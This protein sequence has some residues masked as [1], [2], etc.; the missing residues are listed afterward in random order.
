MFS[1]NFGRFAGM[2]TK[3]AITGSSMLAML[4]AF[5][6]VNAQTTY[7]FNDENFLTP[8]NPPVT[9]CTGDACGGEIFLRM[10]TPVI[11]GGKASIG[12]W[13]RVESAL[14][15]TV[16]YLGNYLFHVA[17]G[18]PGIT[19]DSQECS[20]GVAE[21][22]PFAYDP[23]G[24][25]VGSN[26]PRSIT[27]TQAAPAST[28]DPSDRTHYTLSVGDFVQFGTFSCPVANG[29]GVNAYIL[30]PS[31]VFGFTIQAGAGDQRQLLLRAD[32]SFRYF[33]LNGDDPFEFAGTV[34]DD[35]TVVT[36]DIT[37]NLPGVTP[38][39]TASYSAVNVGE[40]T[41][42]CGAPTSDSPVVDGN[43]VTVTFSESQADNDCT[44]TFTVTLPDGSSYS[45]DQVVGTSGTPAEQLARAKA[46]Y[47][48]GS[49]DAYTAYL[50]A[51]NNGAVPVSSDGINEMPGLVAGVFVKKILGD[52]VKDAAT[53]DDVPSAFL[54]EEVQSLLDRTV[55][56][57]SGADF[58]S[59]ALTN[60]YS[61]SGTVRDVMSTQVS[62]V[63]NLSN[64]NVTV[65]GVLTTETRLVKQ[66]RNGNWRSVV[67]NDM[68][69]SVWY[70]VRN[71]GASNTC[72]GG[73]LPT[74]NGLIPAGPSTPVSCIM[75]TIVD[76]GM[77]DA[78][79][80][81]EPGSKGFISDPIV[82]VAESNKPP[83]P[84]GGGGGGGGGNGF[85]GIGSA[86]AWTIMA[87]LTVLGLSMLRRRRVTVR[88]EL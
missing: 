30:A 86:G 39:V 3:K 32:N 62:F 27:I 15:D 55:S 74:D 14:G 69:G 60:V 43:Q 24:L 6:N 83:L 38:T 85:L 75:I 37:N 53:R 59:S 2:V 54:A 47:I 46:S 9:E 5:A 65:G 10:G 11:E 26:D 17:T 88:S 80:R 40:P 87:L 50:K 73:W 57:P 12:I 51:N 21:D 1:I 82:G 64:D 49:V 45:Y 4:L 79:G 78:D 44:V 19:L 72:V 48:N 67:N 31:N 41:S 29:D 34:N 77:Y 28:R 68:D 84:G 22:V 58:E 35:G 18:G 7:T 71:S 70:L 23:P 20:F 33:P 66:L 63:I 76:D 56:G 16:P 13:L 25:A 52:V 36:L 8:P 81:T 61:F 42:G